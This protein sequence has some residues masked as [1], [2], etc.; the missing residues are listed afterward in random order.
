MQSHDSLSL[1]RCLSASSVQPLPS[2]SAMQWWFA[3]WK[4]DKLPNGSKPLTF[5]HIRINIPVFVQ[6]CVYT[7]KTVINT[8]LLHCANDGGQFAFAQKVFHV[9]AFPFGQRFATLRLG[10][11][12]ARCA[13]SKPFRSQSETIALQIFT[14]VHVGRAP[15]VRRPVIVAACKTIGR[16]RI[17]CSVDY[18]LEPRLLRKHPSIG[19]MALYISR[20]YHSSHSLR[21]GVESASWLCLEIDRGKTNT[22]TTVTN[23]SFGTPVRWWTA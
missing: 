4:Y 18:S 21:G 1:V 3:I 20:C 5:V 7:Y 9:R 16:A 13:R 19:W 17:V 8:T 14:I 15:P 11:S 10:C 6:R 2:W 12:S 22:T 23:G